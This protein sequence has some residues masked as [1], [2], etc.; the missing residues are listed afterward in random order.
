MY[1]VLGQE[2]E[3]RLLLPDRLFTVNESG[4]TVPVS[5]YQSISEVIDAVERYRPDIVFLFSGYLLAINN[6]F[7]MG[8]VAR[9]VPMLRDRCGRVVTSDPFLGIQARLDASTFNAPPIKQQLLREHFTRVYEILKPVTHLYLV[10]PAEFAP[11][12]AVSF[13]NENLIRPAPSVPC[14]P[15]PLA[16]V[17]ADRARP[18]W[19]FVLSDEDYW[20]HA[21]WNGLRFD[22]LLTDKLRETAAA[23][24]QP[25]LVAPRACTSAV[26]LRSPPID[27]LI[28][29]PSCRYQLFLPLV[30]EAE[31]A[32]YWNIF[33]N[34]ILPRLLNRC[35]VFFFDHGHLARAIPPLFAEGLRRYYG[36]STLPYRPIE[37]PLEAGP[38][39]LQA[40]DQ[41]RSLAP[42][43]RCLRASPPPATMVQTLLKTL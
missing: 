34:S 29:L 1:L 13:S 32:F 12:D 14:P 37:Q 20:N 27:G 10:E 38:L 26:T 21:G 35:P 23:G 36:G 17:G 25:L 42:A 41:A 18:R 11:T 24:R 22:D 7:T 5:A 4:L 19:M 15:A 3:T 43:E 6:I 2:F 16:E 40:S 31:Y 9:L 30:L 33:S 8:D 39:A 28:L